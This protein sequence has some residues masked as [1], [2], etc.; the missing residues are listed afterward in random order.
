MCKVK[1]I[2]QID[3]R[4]QL[5]IWSKKYYVAESKDPFMCKVKHIGQ[6]LLPC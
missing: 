1:R 3:Q 6:S 2:G 4:Y 5:Q